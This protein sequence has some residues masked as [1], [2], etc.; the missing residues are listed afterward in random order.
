MGTGIPI[1]T[2][3]NNPTQGTPET[4]V[5]ITSIGADGTHITLSQPATAVGTQSLDFI[6]GLALDGSGM[7]FIGNNID[8]QDVFTQTY[9]YSSTNQNPYLLN[10]NQQNLD[11]CYILYHNTGTTSGMHSVIGDG[12]GFNTDNYYAITTTVTITRSTPD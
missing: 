9:T 1:P 8:T 2:L 5:V 7:E 12:P 3:P 10:F 4:K 11:A 6:T